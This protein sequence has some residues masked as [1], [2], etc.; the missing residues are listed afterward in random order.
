MHVAN[1]L[2]GGRWIDLLRGGGT[3]GEG[4]TV[5]VYQIIY[6][7]HFSDPS[8]KESTFINKIAYMVNILS[9]PIRP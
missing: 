4:Y 8:V 3:G 1:V 9:S 5:V 6:W 2:M 7:Y